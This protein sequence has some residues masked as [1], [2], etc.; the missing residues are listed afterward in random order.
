MVKSYS[1]Y[2]DYEEGPRCEDGFITNT[3]G[4][5][6][7][8]IEHRSALLRYIAWRRER[9]WVNRNVRMKMRRTG[10]HLKVLT[11][12]A[13]GRSLPKSRTCTLSLRG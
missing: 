7:F 3:V 10:G 13:S 6:L 4:R 12:D 5:E 8:M 11:W 2:S 9:N 1:W